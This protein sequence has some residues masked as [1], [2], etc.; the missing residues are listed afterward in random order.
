MVKRTSSSSL[1]VIAC[2]LA[3]NHRNGNQ[4]KIYNGTDLS[5][6]LTPLALR[7]L[8]IADNGSVS[9]IGA[10]TLE[11]FDGERIMLKKSD[12]SIEAIDSDGDNSTELLSS[13][14][15]ASHPQIYA[16]QLYYVSSAASSNST[17]NLFLA[18][19]DGSFKKQLSFIPQGIQNRPVLLDDGDALVAIKSNYQESRLPSNYCRK[20]SAYYD[21]NVYL[22]GTEG[23]NVAVYDTLKDSFSTL[24]ENIPFAG[25]FS[26]ADDGQGKAYFYIPGTVV[27]R[28]GPPIIEYCK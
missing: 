6:N 13:T 11:G 2:S 27:S 1:V 19:T 28:L 8:H 25:N 24:P 18:D 23:S 20:C 14:I 21:N 3:R 5:P 26:C 16:N 10:A 9:A 15:Q 7:D 12:N 22:F 4:L 17:N